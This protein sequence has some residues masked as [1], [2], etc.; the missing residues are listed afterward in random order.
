MASL[1]RSA[2]L[3]RALVVAACLFPVIQACG[4]SEPGDYLYNADGTISQGATSS[5]SAGRSS[6]G[7]TRN[8]T[9]GANGTGGS[10]TGATTS[11]GG[12]GPIGVGGAVT[13]GG[14]GPIPQGGEGGTGIGGTPAQ[15]GTASVTP[16]SCGD[17]VCIAETEACCAGLAGLS[18][19]RQ[20]QTCEGAVLGCTINADCNGNDVCCISITGNAAE[21]SSCKPR[22]DNMG[23]G[24][25]R[26]LCQS[27]DECRM[28]FRFC[29]PTIFGV[30]ICTR[31]P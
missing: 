8:G 17:D 11:V 3:L 31:R 22:C 7:G 25:D 9:A 19:V 30:N 10:G 26:Q 23:T 13:T 1:P 21:A 15:G 16:I 14:G 20:G 12:R 29:T 24:R 27:D 28:P 2:R 4:R 5:T 6:T 18:C